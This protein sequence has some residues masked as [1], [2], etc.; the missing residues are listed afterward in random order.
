[1]SGGNLMEEFKLKADAWYCRGEERSRVHGVK[2][3][4]CILS[5]IDVKVISER[6]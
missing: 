5:I 6:K 4:N 3:V 1:M 2:L